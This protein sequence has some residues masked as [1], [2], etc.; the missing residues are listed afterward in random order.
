MTRPIVTLT[1]NPAI[2][3]TVWVDELVPGTTHRTA[4]M[5]AT[6]G[7]K[8]INVARVV[9]RIG[10]PVVALGLAGEDQATPIERY[11]DSLGVPSRFIRTPGETRTNLKVIEQATGRLTE[12]NGSGPEV[13]TDQVDELERELLSVV[14][15]R[16]A[17]AVVFAGSL[18]RG[19]DASV[20][21]RWTEILRGAWPN[22]RV[23]ADTSD[24]ALERITRAG[25]FF[26]KPNRVE[27]AA[28]TG[29][30]IETAE[31]AQVAAREIIR[32]GA[33][34]V[35]V[36]LGSAGSVAAWGAEVEV[37]S[38]NQ[39][40]VPPGQLQTTVGAG[41][42]M[43][44]RIAVELAKLDGAHVGPKAFF[45][46]CRLAAA[47]AEA[48]IGGVVLSREPLGPTAS[49]YSPITPPDDGRQGVV[50]M[51]DG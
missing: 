13:S 33:R 23:L 42:A 6:F 14:E 24:E 16:R 43:V 25:P 37:L 10:A 9:A 41:D 27:A 30:R 51:V 18:P 34:G 19:V 31:D 45:A 49:G 47:E 4:D 29:R 20:Y 21:A 32:Q 48:Q 44:A 38:P 2:D 12:I 40:E 3:R 5:H 22:L 46:M 1:L 8:G 50:P 39:I 28:L 26:L 36:S 15:G 17:A 7:G 35:L 11:L